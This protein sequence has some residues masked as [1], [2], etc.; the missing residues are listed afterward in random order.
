MGATPMQTV[1]GRLEQSGKQPRQHGNQ[2]QARCPAHND[3]NPSL[4]IAPG[5][6]PDQ[7]LLHCHAGCSIED[8]TAAIGL[9][10]KDLYAPKTRTG[11]LTEIEHYTYTDAAGLNTMRVHRFHPKTFRQSHWNGTTWQ[12][13]AKHIPPTLYRLP[14][15]AEAIETGDTIYLVEGERDVHTL[16]ELGHTATTNAGGAGKFKPEHAQQLVGAAKVI[17]IA[18]DDPPGHKH[19]EQAAAEINWAGIQYT[20]VTCATGCKDISDH[21]AAGHTLSDLRPYTPTAEDPETPLEAPE[22]DT[23]SFG[24]GWTP[25]DLAEVLGADYT[26]PVPT[27]GTRTDTVG[28]FYAGRVNALFGE[29]GSGK[30]W[31]AMA[32][33]AQQ[34]KAGNQVC[35]IDHEDHAGSVT[36]RMLK[37]GCTVAEIV[38]QLTYIRPD[39]AWNQLAAID[40]AEHIT[41]TGTT[42]VVCDSTGEGMSL[43]GVDPNSDDGVAKWMRG[44]ARYIANLGPCVLLLDHMP[45]ANDSNKA[46]MIGSQ[47]KKAAIDG[48]AYRVDVG[49]APA[50]GIDGQL[51]LIV[52]KD[53][54][55][56]HQHG[57]KVA[58]ITISDTATGIDVTIKPPST[59]LPTVLMGRI[60][61]YIEAAGPSSTNAIQKHVEGN[62]KSL[63]TAL[64]KLMDLGYVQRTVKT[65]IGGGFVHTNIKPFNELELLATTATTATTASQPRPDAL[66]PTATTAS[67]PR[68][69]EVVEPP[70]FTSTTSTTSLLVVEGGRGQNTKQT[71]TTEARPS[72]II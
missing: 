66:N 34:I 65:G 53:R 32:T 45:K 54:G 7:V 63:R 41:N 15:V 26:P 31:V 42:L 69:D 47:R 38:A 43:D 19:A 68:P 57:S 8:I 33:C 6:E 3:N 20:I 1:I 62:S 22:S 64:E 35:Y 14:K 50:R 72:D 71:N 44:F 40:L 55:G 30:S 11:E 70:K 36:N 24:H 52:A 61:E 56:Y 9:E 10:P 12:W 51:K 2:Y 4:S 60:S 16:E 37:L 59:G 28:L 13:G 18:D 21:L 25:D 29:S 23:D 58:D 39:R 49:V 27:I 67:Q 17:I 5:T 46:F 48:A